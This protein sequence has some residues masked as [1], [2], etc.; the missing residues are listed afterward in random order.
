VF[1]V[2]QMIATTNAPISLPGAG[3]V[4]PTA[5]INALVKLLQNLGSVFKGL[6]S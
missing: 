1:H 4:D 5:Y 3:S 2:A 6:F